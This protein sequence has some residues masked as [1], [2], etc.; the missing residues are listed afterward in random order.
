MQDTG[1]LWRN[2]PLSCF[3]Y[4]WRG[5]VEMDIEVLIRQITECEKTLDSLKGQMD[6]Q[7]I[8]IIS[9]IEVYLKDKFKHD[10]ESNVKSNTENTKKL[11]LEKLSELKKELNT[12]IDQVPELVNKK[13]DND[14][15]WLLLSYSLDGKDE[16]NSLFN[17]QR[18]IKSNIDNSIRELLG[19]S[20]KILIDYGYKDYSKDSSWEKQYKSDVPR[21]KYGF[22]VSAKVNDE[23][24]A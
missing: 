20:G 3:F 21:Y 9:E 11:G 2:Y 10:I 4:I 12:L 8:K 14:E 7:K 17:A 16:F 19:Y 1:F 22:S 5:E 18:N 23:I 13:F 15:L 6:G 24:T